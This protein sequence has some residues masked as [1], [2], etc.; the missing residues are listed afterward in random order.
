MSTSSASAGGPP[1]SL[2]ESASQIVE[3]RNGVMK[4][5]WEDDDE[6]NAS[7]SG[8]ASDSGV[9]SGQGAGSDYSDSLLFWMPTGRSSQGSSEAD[10]SSR[11]SKS[12]QKH[13]SVPPVGSAD[14]SSLPASS[15]PAAAP[16]SIATA[17]LLEDVHSA[18]LE[19]RPVYPYGGS[20]AEM[21]KMH[22]IG[23]L[24]AEM[25]STLL[26][27]D[28][29]CLVADLHDSDPL[30]SND[31]HAHQRFPHAHLPRPPGNFLP[32]R[33]YAA[34]GATVQASLWQPPPPPMMAP[35]LTLQ[36]PQAQ[37]SLP[38]LEPSLLVH[39]P[40]SAQPPA[41]EPSHQSLPRQPQHQE[42][43][44]EVDGMGDASLASLVPRN[45]EGELTSL[46]SRR[47]PESCSP[48]IFWFRKLCGK[49]LRCEF[50]HFTHPG[51][52]SKRIRPSKNTRMQMRAEARLKAP[53]VS[54][55]QDVVLQ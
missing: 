52:K 9:L 19:K 49:G 44:A 18:G 11:K 54:T 29:A 17:M 39:H 22:G 2:A 40:W 7:L 3:L 46:G 34:V 30:R 24:P 13:R 12:R 47:H 26:P 48:C 8:S 33:E 14:R 21:H 42:D 50:C 32:L 5:G 1:L 53:A 38:S 27:S 41:W 55:K 45:N 37:T 36:G 51:Q 15:L 10:S 20:P 23:P 28:F 4:G 6:S 31:N 16:A 25:Q 43:V 35:E